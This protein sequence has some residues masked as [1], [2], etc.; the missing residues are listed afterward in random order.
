MSN[1]NIRDRVY[2]FGQRLVD[3]AKDE[4]YA[5]PDSRIHTIV[6]GASDYFVRLRR[7][8][9]EWDQRWKG[10]YKESSFPQYLEET[11]GIKMKMDD[12]GIDIAYD[13]IDEKKHTLFLLKFGA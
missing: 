3:R 13:I 7:V 5:T 10:G 4:Y 11:Y 1:K 9:A 2:Q 8:K 12:S 6:G